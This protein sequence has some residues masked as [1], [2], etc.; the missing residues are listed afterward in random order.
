MK[1]SAFQKTGILKVRKA[2]ESETSLDAV[3]FN[4]NEVNIRIPWQYLNFTDPSARLVMDDDRSTNERETSVSDG[5]ALTF[6][7]KK[8]I[9]VTDR[10]IW[11]TWNTAPATTERVKPALSI[12]SA[13]NKKINDKPEAGKKKSGRKK[14]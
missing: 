4:G 1:Y 6:S 10:Y 12:I 2:G 9:A 7:Y 14:Q 13:G 5:I 11:D 8:E 3:W